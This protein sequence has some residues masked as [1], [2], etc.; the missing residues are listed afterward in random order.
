MKTLLLSW[1]MLFWSSFAD[2]A[3]PSW[4][5]AP[6]TEA[7]V[8][9]MEAPLPDVQEDWV[10]YTDPYATVYAAPGDQGTAL[11]MSRYIATS[12]PR[13]AEEM[14]LPIGNRI[15]VYIAPSQQVFFEMQPGR[16]PDWADGTAYPHRGLIFLR[17]PKL[18]VGSAEP[19]EQVLDHEIA[20]ILLG[21]AFGAKPVPRWLQEGVAQ[22]VAREYTL[23]VVDRLGQGVFGDDLMSVDELSQGFPADP[24]RAR[25]AYAQSAD[26]VAFIYN[27][28]GQK[29]LHDIIREM[30]VGKTF[31]A[32][33]RASTGMRT[34]ELDAAWRGRLASSS[35]LWLRPLV[36]DTM[37][38]SFAGLGFMV[39]GGLALRK[40]RKQLHEMADEEDAVEAWYAQ[41]SQGV[42]D[43]DDGA[44]DAI[45][46][47]LGD[48]DYEQG[49]HQ[50]SYGPH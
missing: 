12:L 31:A 9:A 10:T 41:L 3:G 6:D 7:V 11:R 40:R 16:A 42:F 25:L 21:R 37:L 39:M 27:Q 2:A 14:G 49:G 15:H 26:L 19:L 29:A 30:S 38:L 13:V 8:A 4:V 43:E 24:I 22:L 33:L 17:S 50:S 34:D 23:D 44:T 36:S 1:L 32:A 18:R 45:Y 5:S 46:S 48:T 20:H 35:M 28:H 47:G